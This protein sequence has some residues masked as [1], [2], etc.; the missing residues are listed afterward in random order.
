MHFF[1]Q[2]RIL[3]LIN[4]P[5]LHGTARALDLDIDFKKLLGIFRERAR[6]IRAIYYAVIP[7]GEEFV[8]VRRLTDWLNYNGYTIVNKSRGETL[9]ST[10]RRRVNGRVDLEIAVDAMRMAD[11]IDHFVLFACDADYSYLIE[12]LKDRGKR[13][14]VVS[15]MQTQPSMVA[16]SLRRSTDEFLDLANI[17]DDIRRDAPAALPERILSQDDTRKRLATSKS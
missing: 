10:G 1:P 3:L 6:V 8:A 7:E 17:A 9:D 4:G 5:S 13:V 11:S 16:D 2:E 14:T 12:A 15:T